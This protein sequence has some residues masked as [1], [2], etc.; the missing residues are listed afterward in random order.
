MEDDDMD[1]SPDGGVSKR[2]VSWPPK[3][4]LEAAYSGPPVDDPQ[5]V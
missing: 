2:A 4:W 1:G 3:A 5:T